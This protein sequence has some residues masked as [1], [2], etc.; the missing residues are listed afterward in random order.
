MSIADRDPSVNPDAAPSA[1]RLSMADVTIPIP[2]GSVTVTPPSIPDAGDII[3]KTT[4]KIF[5]AVMGPIA[6]LVL[7]ALLAFTAQALL[8]FAAIT[9][10]SRGSKSGNAGTAAVAGATKKVARVAVKAAVKV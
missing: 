6:E 4:D 7:T 8:V 3:G 5:S 1:A 10:V 9:A 2:G